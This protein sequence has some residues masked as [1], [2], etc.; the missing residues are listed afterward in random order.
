M[1]GEHL[2]S[3]IHKSHQLHHDNTLHVIRVISNP[4]RYHSRYRLARKQEEFLKTCPNI[5]LYTVE[6]SFGHRCHELVEKTNP[7]HLAVKTNSEI[8]VKENM[9][10]LGV[11]HLL[12]KDWK[13]VA[14]I[15]GDVIWH[16]TNWAQE[17]LHALQ[18]Y[19]V[20]QPW[21]DGLDLGNH[22]N[23]LSHFKSFGFQ[24]Y[25]QFENEFNHAVNKKKPGVI[26]HKSP[27][28]TSMPGVDYR[29]FGHTG[30]A[31]ACT[32]H[33]WENVGGLMDFCILGSADHNMATA[34]VGRVEQSIHQ[35]MSDGFKQK[36]EEW[37]AKAVRVT[38]EEVGSTMERLE[39]FFHGKK[40]NRFYGARWKILIHYKFDPIK[41]L[42]YDDQGILVLVGK[43]KLEQAIRHYIRSRNE[44][45][46]AEF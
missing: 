11:K 37:Q 8:W 35:G 19:P 21:M 23:V 25:R 34:M 39:H 33:F 38:H 12:P 5:V 4:A 6:A 18:H 22:G 2:V 46:I 7:H 30:Y 15:D 20:I 14:W 17:A 36:C 27:P 13:Y 32:R 42:M 43:P 26:H 45:D 10:N 40:I 1:Y 3:H 31:W 24:H 16:N 41:D 9:I 44:D 28:A 29:R